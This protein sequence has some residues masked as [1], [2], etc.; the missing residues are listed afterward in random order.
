[1]A[2]VS[3]FTFGSYRVD[4]PRSV[5]TFTYRVAFENG[6]IKS[7]TDT[8]QLPHTTAEMWGNIPKSVLEPTLQALLLV[9][10]INY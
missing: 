7:F 5:I 1:M 10:G 2:P 3:S 8:L 9:L 4:T 6:K